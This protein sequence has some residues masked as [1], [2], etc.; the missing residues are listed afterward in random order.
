MDSL[1]RSPNGFLSALPDDDFGLIRPHLR[2]VDLA[3][4]LV[5]AEAD[6]TLKRAYLPH[7]GVISLVVRLARGE[8][9]QVAMIGRECIFGAAA[10]L[11]SFVS[12]S[13]GSLGRSPFVTLALARTRSL[14]RRKLAADPRGPG[15]GTNDRGTTQRGVARRPR[16]SAGRHHQIQPRTYPYYG[17]RWSERNFL[18]MLSGGQGAIRPTAEAVRLTLMPPPTPVAR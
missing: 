5:L 9:V 8:H 2:T 7:S 14:R 11:G 1:P 17:H 10:A 15:P 18:R 12:L 16:A 6:E 3:S 13:C 4:E